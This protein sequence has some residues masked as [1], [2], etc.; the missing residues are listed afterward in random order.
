MSEE[1]GS[2]DHNA[3]ATGISACFGEQPARPEEQG[4]N[5]LLLHPPSQRQQC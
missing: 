2:G 5:L 1:G 4:T 3:A